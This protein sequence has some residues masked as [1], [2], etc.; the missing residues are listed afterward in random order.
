[1]RWRFRGGEAGEAECL[2]MLNVQSIGDCQ[3]VGALGGA[4]LPRPVVDRVPVHLAALGKPGLGL[5]LLVE[6]GFDQV[7]EGPCG[8]VFAHA[9]MSTELTRVCGPFSLPIC[10]QSRIELPR[11]DQR[12]E[13]DGDVYLSTAQACGRLNISRDTLAKR[14]REG[15]LEA[16]KGPA[17]NSHVKVL[18]SSIEAYEERRRIAVVEESV[19]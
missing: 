3:H 15:E 11:V 14:I 17:R 4:R 18:L 6:G 13:G 12:K 8:G 2:V 5:A 10:A 16:I 1:M 7:V 9:S 19:A